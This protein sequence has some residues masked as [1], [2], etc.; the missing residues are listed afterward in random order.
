[1]ETDNIF[2][3]LDKSCSIRNYKKTKGLI[4]LDK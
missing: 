4:E 3:F 1:M 2:F